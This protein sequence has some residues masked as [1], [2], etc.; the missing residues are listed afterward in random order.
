MILSQYKFCKVCLDTDGSLKEYKNSLITQSALE[1][2]STNN[3]KSQNARRIA[4]TCCW[5]LQPFKI[6]EKPGFQ[7]FVKFLNPKTI[8]PSDRTIAAT[9]LNDVYNV[10]VGHVKKSLENCPKKRYISN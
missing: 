3:S 4:E 10:Y 1:T 8:L 6:V 5:D 9:A 2:T 7:K